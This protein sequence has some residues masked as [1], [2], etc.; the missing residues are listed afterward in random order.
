MQHHAP[1]ATG[2]T[3]SQWNLSGSSRSSFRGIATPVISRPTIPIAIERLEA[4]KVPMAVSD[5]SG[6][7]QTV[8]NKKID[9]ALAWPRIAEVSGN[10]GFFEVSRCFEVRC[11]EQLAIIE[12]SS[13]D[14]SISW[15][16]ASLRC[17]KPMNL[18][19]PSA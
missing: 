3:R 8:P 11:V 7:S 10:H 9:A 6:A 2:T 18:N 4:V 1:F 15:A 14:F 19:V 5:R 12:T 13:T 16:G 17:P